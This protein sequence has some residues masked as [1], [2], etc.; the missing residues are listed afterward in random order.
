MGVGRWGLEG[1]RGLGWGE[2]GTGGK[3]KGLGET[4]GLGG[5]RRLRGC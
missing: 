1:I 3:T 2:Q 5:V 4:R